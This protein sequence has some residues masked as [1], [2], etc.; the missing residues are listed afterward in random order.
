[1]EFQ[2]VVEH[3]RMVR[4]FDP[5]VLVGP[6]VFG[7]PRALTPIGALAIGHRAPD[8][9]SPSLKRGRRSIEVAVHRGGWYTLALAHRSCS[10]GRIRISLIAT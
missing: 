8:V 6:E 2:K 9:P 1:M 5:D 3:R 7:A 10:V 4:N